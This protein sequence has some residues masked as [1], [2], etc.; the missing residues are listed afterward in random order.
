[1]LKNKIL[2]PFIYWLYKKVK[3]PGIQIEGDPRRV[4]I[5]VNS[6]ISNTALLS[7]KYGGCINIGNDCEIH[8][9]VVLASYGGDIEVGNDCSFNPYCVVYGHGGLH[10]GND[11]RVA[12]QT[13]IV[14]ANHNFIDKS[15]CIKE[16]GLTRQGIVIG[17]DV[18]IGAGVKI[19]DGTKISNGAV[20][21]AGAVVNKNIGA[22]EVHG[23]VPNKMITK[24]V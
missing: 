23:G 19:L 13:V 16:Q 20:V 11:V 7:V 8:H 4:T 24:R 9:G 18:W 2:R 12:T 22:Y 17:N 10:I 15:K 1:M 5:G 14:P 3:F 6:V 21:A